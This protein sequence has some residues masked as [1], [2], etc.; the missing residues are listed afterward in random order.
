MRNAMI[1][2]AGGGK[3]RRIRWK[4][5]L[6]FYIMVLPGLLYLLLNN[7]VP[8]FGILIA[9]KNMNFQ[10]GI[11]GSP[12]CGFDNFRFLF[13][14]SA[15]WEIL[16]NTVGYNVLFHIVGT[17]LAILVAILINEI[18]S[19]RIKKLYQSLLLL[20]YLI[21]W[22]IV[23]YLVYAYFSADTGLVNN[24]IL[25]PLGLEPIVWYQEPK[26]W[27]F[28]LLFFNVWKGIGYSMIVYLSSIV[29]ISSDYF[30]A[31]RIDG[32]SKWKQIRYITLPLLKPTIITL[33]I[34]AVGGIFR[35]DFGLFYQVPRNSG[36]LYPVTR[37]L[38][39]YVYQALLQN[40]DYGMSSAASVYQ[41]VVG[42]VMILLTNAVIR[43]YEADSALF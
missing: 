2:A 39:V 40:A 11:L 4:R 27:P 32:A 38:D 41:S 6:P 7:Y 12:W 29:G 22:V 3:R 25:K 37:T 33:S 20:P 34:L 24:S 36:I 13:A 31:A 17:V 26:Y 18:C 16:R 10:K 8:M 23:S 14:S 15:G 19:Q 43:K 35:S 9:F 30:E 5:I 1:P 21:S 42:F 28:L